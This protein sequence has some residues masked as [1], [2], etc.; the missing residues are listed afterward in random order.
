[1]RTGRQRWPIM[2][3][4]SFLPSANPITT[5]SAS[6]N[7]PFLTRRLVR[8]LS[9][10]HT[11]PC[12]DSTTWITPSRA[13]S[14]RTVKPMFLRRREARLPRMCRIL[15]RIATPSARGNTSREARP[16]R[17]PRKICSHRNHGCT[18]TI[19]TRTR[20]TS[21]YD[22]RHHRREGRAAERMG[23]ERHRN[24]RPLAVGL[25]PQ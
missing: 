13:W 16:I 18:S 6:H 15:D 4:M 19:K 9:H 2:S 11:A 7:A 22:Y 12:D 8:G 17:G 23:L 21:P 10:E 3:T 14:T 25:Q 1:M 5:H 24:H 20:P